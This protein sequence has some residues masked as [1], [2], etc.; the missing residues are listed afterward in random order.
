MGISWLIIW[1]LICFTLATWIVIGVKFG[2][3]LN[4]AIIFLWLNVI[5]LHSNRYTQ[6]LKFNTMINMVSASI[7][8]LSESIA[9]Q[10]KDLDS[11]HNWINSVIN[12]S[13]LKTT[14]NEQLH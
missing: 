2:A 10:S 1:A 7:Q 3:A 9:L 11:I 4:A 6:A 12:Y 5:A 8:L 14:T 13:N